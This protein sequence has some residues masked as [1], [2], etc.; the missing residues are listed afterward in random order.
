M[1]LSRL[2]LVGHRWAGLASSAVLCIAGVTGALLVWPGTHLLWRISGPLHDSLGLGRAGWIVVLAVT[3]ASVMVQVSGVVL[4]WR[5]KTFR[6]RIRHGWA[7][8]AAD[9]HHVLGALALPIMIVIASSAIGRAAVGVMD[10]SN[11]RRDVRSAL[12]SFHTSREF[13]VPVRVLYTIGSL[14][15]ALQG[16]TG[17]LMWWQRRPDA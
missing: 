3:A 10:S 7:S 4:W 6:I 2:A 17:V 1:S 5:G 13:P 14:A 16:A 9:A 15:F 11:T 8:A 12:T